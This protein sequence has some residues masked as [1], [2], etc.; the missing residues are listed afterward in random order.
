MG[1]AFLCFF[2]LMPSPILFG[3]IM[4]GSCKI[5]NEKCGE[6]GNCLLYD[7][8]RFRFLVNWTS[9]AFTSIGV[10]FDVLVWHHSKHLDLYGPAD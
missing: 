7:R 8:D 5:W 3:K 2:A 10:F 4:D 1:V 6:R 9:V